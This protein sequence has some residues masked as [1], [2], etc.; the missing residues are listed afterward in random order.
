MVVD[1]GVWCRLQLPRCIAQGGV[2]RPAPKRMDLSLA[3]RVEPEL[4]DDLDAEDP[5]A[6][7]SRGDLQRIQR[8]MATLPIVERALDRGT[9]GFAP[10][11]LLELG[12]GDGSLMMRL[13]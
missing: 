13:G 12:A 10:R 2:R 6:R 9:S 7:R 8:A 3:R 5:R 1:V 11:T 4:L